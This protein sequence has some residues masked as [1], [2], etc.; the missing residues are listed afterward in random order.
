MAAGGGDR[1]PARR[2][3]RAALL[4]A[5]AAFG[6]L[7]CEL[8]VRY[9]QAAVPAPPRSPYVPDPWTGY[10]LRPS[11]SGRFP[12]DDDRHVNRFGFRDRERGLFKRAGA[13][14]VLGVGDSFVYGAVP[15]RRNFLRRAEEAAQARLAPPAAAPEV[16]LLGLPGWN[17][18]NQVGLLRGPARALDP[19]LVVLAFS[20]GSDVTGI[21]VRGVVWQGNLHFVGAQR[22]W[23]DR[24]RRSRLFVLYEQI[25]R[26]RFLR[27]LAGL[28]NR[29]GGPAGPAAAPA[30]GPET[31]P[32]AGAAPGPA[33]APPRRY[34]LQE[35]YL[36]PLF[37]PVPP[38]DLAPLWAEAERQLGAFD[39]ACR[40]A[41]VPWLLLIVP[42]DLQ[43][44]PDLRAQVLAELGGDA[45]AF[46]FDLPQRRLAAFAAAHGVPVLDPLPA[47]RAAHAA[48]AP[49]YLPANNHWNERG[50]RL[51]G[52]LLGAAI[53]GAPPAAG[54]AGAP[55]IAA[56]RSGSR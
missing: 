26:P 10:R 12:E 15:V 2:L 37:E 1:S 23:L 35:S 24:L 53:A 44:D 8:A 18:E 14:R 45:A 49:L 36:L 9:Y 28:R 32:A 20:V 38:P 4:A 39:A 34:L 3:V 42:A 52:D 55:S 46:D 41:D 11:P 21:P 31:L 17:T 22:P 5:L 40:E 7:C 54:A 29:H 30:V 19:D 25:Y 6:L 50:N 13:R 56:L 47:L 16:L 43:V 51:V 27:W 33:G 48:D